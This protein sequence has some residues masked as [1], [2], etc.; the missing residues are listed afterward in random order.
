MMNDKLLFK[1]GTKFRTTDHLTGTEYF[2]F[3]IDI[4]NNIAF[5]GWYVDNKKKFTDYEISNINDQIYTG[6]WIV[7]VATK[8]RNK[9][10]KLEKFKNK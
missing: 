7:D 4:K 8:R 6:N 2:I 1:E 3:D 10:I 5:V 9:L